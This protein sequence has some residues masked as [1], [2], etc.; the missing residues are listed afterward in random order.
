M[1]WRACLT[2]C[3]DI[4]KLGSWAVKPDPSD[5]AV[6]SCSRATARVPGCGGRQG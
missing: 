6:A 1:G 3:L 2:R 4:S 5:F